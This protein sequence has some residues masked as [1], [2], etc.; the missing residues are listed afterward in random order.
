ME[1]TPE[2]PT[3]TLLFR[4]FSHVEQI[5]HSVKL[6]LN[7]RV[8]Q[9]KAELANELRR[10]PVSQALKMN[11]QQWYIS[12][13]ELLADLT[14]KDALEVMEKSTEAKDLDKIADLVEKLEKLGGK[15][16]ELG[17]CTLVVA[18]GYK[19][20]LKQRLALKDIRLNAIG[21]LSVIHQTKV[22]SWAET[23]MGL[24]N[25]EEKAGNAF[26][27]EAENAL[28][29]PI[30]CPDVRRFFTVNCRQ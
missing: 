22:G 29:R 8:S 21:N 20:K 30:S 23:D 16:S 28:E 19:D 17:S 5:V 6:P 25:C 13:Q 27:I 26:L 10:G 24:N 1:L 7:F 15:D 2:R 18:H 11:W 12:D 4:L 9:A 14:E 3:R